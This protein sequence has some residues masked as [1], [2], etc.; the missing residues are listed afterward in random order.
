MFNERV[1]KAAAEIPL[2]KVSTYKEIAKKLKSKGYRAVGGALKH[3]PDPINVPCFRV[4]KSDGSIGGY[5]G[6]DPK[7]IRK[8]IKKLRSEGIVVKNGKVD[9]KKYLF[10]FK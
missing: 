4:I 3:N 1:Y 9:L 10:K 6:S 8:K 2:G 7:N 5:S